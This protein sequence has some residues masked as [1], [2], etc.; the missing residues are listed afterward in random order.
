[1]NTGADFSARYFDDGQL[2]GALIVDPVGA[3]PARDQIFVIQFYVPQKDSAGNPNFTNSVL[4]FNGRP[5]P[6]T[7]RMEYQQGDSVRWRF[8]NASA[9]VHPLHLHGF[10]F[11]VTSRGDL[12][13]DTLYS[14]AQERMGV[15]EFFEEQTTATLSWK[16]DRPGGW[17]FHCHLSFH[18]TPVPKLGKEMLSD[19]AMAKLLF[20]A[21]DMDEMHEMGDSHAEKG[22]GNLM[23][24]MTIKP[25]AT[26]KP[27][28]GP[29]ERLRL[30]IQT[31][32]TPADTA[33]RF[34]YALAKGSE[35]PGENDVQWPGPPIILHKD[36]PTSIMVI[37]RSTEPSQVHWHGLEIDSYY[38]GVAGISS[39]GGMVSPMI[40]PRDSFEVTL[41]PPRSGS[42]MYHTHINDIR[43]QSHGLYGPIVVLD[44]GERWNPE[45]DLIFQV[46]TDPTVTA[47]LNGSASPPAM[48]LHA[49]TPYRVRLMNITLDVPFNQLWLTSSTGLFPLWT[50]LAKDG[51]DLPEWQRDPRQA[52]QRVSIGETYDF[53]ITFPGPGEYEMQGRFGSGTI[54]GRQVI[55]V[56]K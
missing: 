7:E 23:I 25:S 20:G 2:N 50:P 4:T 3:A 18:V 11:R 48:T 47:I 16:A 45:S 14:R 10:Y 32:S 53:S 22:M 27:Y 42:F 54:Y 39:N 37:N 19:S 34:G 40:F 33:R 8:I 49:G 51:Y 46:G 31:D 28:V 36:Q 21:P 26:W 43:Q 35:M 17:I 1:M 24:A 29:R 6:Y 55:H 52:R 30:Y 9:D 41:I 38:D 13:R 12:Q 15:T 56:V 44:S 5:W